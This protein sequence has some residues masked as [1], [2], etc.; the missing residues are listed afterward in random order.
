MASCFARWGLNATGYRRPI[1][2]AHTN[3]L[4]VPADDW[5]QDTCHGAAATLFVG[6]CWGIQV[7]LAHWG[8]MPISQRGSSFAIVMWD[9]LVA[10]AGLGATPSWQGVE[11][12]AGPTQTPTIPCENQGS[13]VE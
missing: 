13:F 7:S 2:W 3:P 4:L 9:A 8:H 6:Q 11:E 12:E 1:N 5:Q 10:P